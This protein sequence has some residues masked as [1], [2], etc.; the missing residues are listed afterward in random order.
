MT[1]PSAACAECRTLIG[2]YVLDALEPDEATAVRGHLADCPDCAAEHARLAGVPALL[3]LVGTDSTAAE[4]PPPALEEAVLDRFAREHRTDRAPARAAAGRGPAARDGRDGDRAHA[5]RA[6]RA[7]LAARL[8]PLRRPLPAAAAGA[9][10]VA[11][12]AAAL[13]VLGPL[14]GGHDGYEPGDTY[15]ARL[16]GSPTA[17]GARA[18]ARLETS[19]AGTRVWL[20]VNGLRGN[21]DDLY[22][23]WC[24]RDDGTKISA[25]TFRVNARGQAAVDL[26]TAA[27]PGEYHRMSVERK[28][29]ERVMAGEIEYGSS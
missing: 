18:F 11:A 2:G 10:V 19:S 16:V 29:G 13:V 15:Q 12:I 14:G 1:A 24:V 6:R 7:W 26:T 21:P 27:V 28:P 22:E 23:L 9:L 8:R 4:S 3:S 20:R 5:R 25:G 17:P